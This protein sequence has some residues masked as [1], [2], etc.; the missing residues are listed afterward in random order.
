M[1]GKRKAFAIGC[2]ILLVLSVGLNIAQLGKIEGLYNRIQNL[3]QAQT[4]Q[5]QWFYTVDSKLSSLSSDLSAENSLLSSSET[6]VE[7]DENKQL[8]A[9][10]SVV[11]KEIGPEDTVYISIGDLRAE[12]VS[13]GTAYEAT[14]AL[15]QY[16][17]D[18]APCITILSPDGTQKQE[19]LANVS[20]VDYFELYYSYDIAQNNGQLTIDVGLQPSGNCV[21][22][23]PQDIE[24][25]WISAENNSAKGKTIPMF[26]DGERIPET[27]GYTS[28]NTAASPDTESAAAS[29]SLYYTYYTAE[30][31]EV[32]ET[33]GEINLICTFE[34]A[35]GLSY[36]I[37]LGAFS[38]NE[39]LHGF[40]GGGNLYP[41]W[42]K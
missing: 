41:E 28:D 10:V 42:E 32:P 11:P 21:L 4:R 19:T 23:L 3:E 15:T 29:G 33:D 14:L 7:I 22:S 20:L 6:T 17:T 24:K 2:G 5:E 31:D 40:G 8:T 25:I 34:T 12:A 16:S 38:A 1:Y 18:F 9:S 26:P 36:K 13:N 30:L 27:S 37:N 35:G 39:K